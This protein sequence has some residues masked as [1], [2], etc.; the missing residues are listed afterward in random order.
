MSR[1]FAEAFANIMEAVRNPTGKEP[2]MMKKLLKKIKN[3][4]YRHKLTILLV[5]ASL[6]PMTVLALYSHS[7]MSSLIR[8]NEMED[9]YSILEQTREGI[10]SQIEVYTS[11]LNYLTY[12]PDIEEIIEDKNMDNYLAYEKYTEVADPLLTVP[13]SYHDAIHQ[14]QLFADSIKVRHEYTLIPLSEIQEEWWSEKLNDEVRVQWLVDEERPEIAAVRK[15][16]SGQELEAALCVTL[17]YEKIFQPFQNIISGE[18]GGMIVDDS[19]KVLYRL[20]N[21]K[22]GELSGLSDS[23]EV[24]EHIREKFAYVSSRSSESGW[25]FY[26][27]KPQSVISASVS[28][29]LLSEIPLIALCA[30]IILL[31]G[32]SFSRLFTR[33]IEQL[34]ENMDQVNHG[35]REVTVYSDSEDEIGLLIRSFR[36]MMNQIDRLIHEV[37]E[38]KIALKEFELKALTAQINPHFLYNSLSIINWMAIRSHQK[39]ISKVT[40]A[41]STFYRTA[42]SK[43][44]DM[45]TVESCIKNI[46]AYLQ[47]QLVMHDNDFQVDWEIDP[48]VK[49]EKVPKLIIQP[50]VENALEHGLDMKEEGE[51]VLRLFF[52]QEAEDVLLAVEDNGLGME[53]KEAET[54]VTYQAEGYGLKNVNDRIRL[55]YGEEYAIRIFSRVGEG[56]R[57]EMRIPKGEPML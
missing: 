14:I 53:Q 18:A 34:T 41:L 37:Y 8:K 1:T 57:V 19:G 54:L 40:L 23:A 17:D 12:A 32:L 38:N 44:E 30:G 20:E 31:L 47:I 52:V 49:N 27:Y 4:K 29:L 33:R 46:E 16:F 22:G 26:L 43:G 11:L 21:M 48:S 50:V 5:V 55:L 24:L 42:L 56:T 45:V 9:M 7:R 15:I 13:K 25:T 28:Q 35:S 10:D 51:K 36:R 2:G 39:E 6:V 3:M